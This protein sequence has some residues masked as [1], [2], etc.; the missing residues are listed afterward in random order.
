VT[1]DLSDFEKVP[2]DP[3]SMPTSSLGIT[4]AV[5]YRRP[6][7]LAA[8][9]LILIIV[10]SV[11]IDLPRPITKAQ[12]VSSQNA[13]IK[14]INTD[15]APC[16]FAVKETF[17][18]YNLDVTG[19]LT[20]SNRA[21]VPT[22]LTGDETACSFASQPVFDLTNNL[23]V[24]DTASGRHI[25]RMKSAV[26]DWM[27]N[28]ALASIKD[29]QYLFDHPGDATTIRHLAKQEVQLTAERASALNDEAQAQQ[30]LGQKLYA[31]KIPT[32]PHLSGT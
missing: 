8:L 25:D 12:D 23:Q 31:L 30:V 11:V 32:L 21:E 29:I 3:A 13:S 9:S 7:V 6:W 17:H 26:Q 14:E 4:K 27:T 20:S 24:D 5:W 28:F 1:D 10:I 22:L 18:I 15:L 16:A 19:K 2:F